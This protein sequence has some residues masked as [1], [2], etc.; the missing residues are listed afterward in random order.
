MDTIPQWE[1]FWCAW[2]RLSQLFLAHHNWGGFL[3]AN[4][5]AWLAMHECSL[6]PDADYGRVNMLELLQ[7]LS[8]QPSGSAQWQWGRRRRKRQRWQWRQQGC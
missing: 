5:K 4:H 7:Y 8:W 1:V 6:P 3:A 2:E